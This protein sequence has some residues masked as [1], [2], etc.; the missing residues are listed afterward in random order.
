MIVSFT[1][2]GKPEPAGSKKHVGRGKIS[3]A[4]PRAQDYKNAVAAVAGS[5]YDAST[6]GLLEGPLRLSVTVHVPRPKGHY[7]KK[8]LLPSAPARPTT[9]PDLTK[10]LRGIEDALTGVVWRDDAQVVSQHAT[11]IFGEPAR[12]TITIQTVGEEAA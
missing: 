8:G 11:K 9:R 4:N 7:G 3:D 12:V 1:V 5:Q 10:L 6:D 2:Y